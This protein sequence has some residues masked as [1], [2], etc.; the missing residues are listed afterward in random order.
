VTHHFGEPDSHAVLMQ[1]NR[2]IEEILGGNLHRT[3]FRPWEIR[4]LVDLASCDL[5][6]SSRCEGVLRDYQNEVQCQMQEGTRLPLK[7]SEY[8][9]SPQVNGY[10]HKP[11]AVGRAHGAHGR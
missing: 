8:L 2:L 11:L 5:R 9:A 7:L 6:G 3:T 10:R 1:F 4:I